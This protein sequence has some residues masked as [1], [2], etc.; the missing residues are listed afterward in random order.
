MR[1]HL[2]EQQRAERVPPAR[3][4]G[5]GTQGSGWLPAGSGGT[6]HN[7]QSGEGDKREAWPCPQ[8]RRKQPGG[9]GGERGRG[10]RGRLSPQLRAT[11]DAS[12]AAAA[13]AHRACGSLNNS[14]AHRG[15]EEMCPSGTGTAGCSQRSG[16]H[17]RVS[18]VKTSNFS[19]PPAPRNPPCPAKLSARTRGTGCRRGGR[20]RKQ[21]PPPGPARA[22]LTP[23][24]FP[25]TA[26]PRARQRS[27][28]PPRSAI[29]PA[30]QHG[31]RR[32]AP[33]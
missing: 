11:A 24:L 31:H 26:S 33:H 16:K 23:A 32:K 29:S 9:G 14:H 20:H 15:E 22:G 13:A 4:A 30:S 28:G 5:R 7:K 19:V 1:R 17:S 25:A 3:G 12:P 6:G 21:P 8:L 18:G 27:P 2:W 10:R